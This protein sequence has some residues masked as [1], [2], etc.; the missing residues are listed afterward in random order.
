MTSPMFEICVFTKA[1]GP[2]TKHI[3]LD[4]DKVVSDGSSCRMTHGTARRVRLGRLQ[5]LAALISGLKWNEAI[6]LGCLRDDLPDRVR[7]VTK[8]ELA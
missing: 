5:D 8:A 2:L 6:A 4:G 7:V 1:G 3:R